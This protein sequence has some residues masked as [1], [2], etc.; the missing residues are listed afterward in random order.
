ME[1]SSPRR[2]KHAPTV[3]LFQEFSLADPLLAKWTGT[4]LLAFMCWPV[5]PVLSMPAS[6]NV[7]PAGCYALAFLVQ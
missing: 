3:P 1:V 6:L 4:Q 2:L 7:T 5:L